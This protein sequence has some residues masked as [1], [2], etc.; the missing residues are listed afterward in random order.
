MSA[1]QRRTYVRA[2]RVGGWVAV[3]LIL[4]HWLTAGHDEITTPPPAP[5]PHSVTAALEQHRGECWH[6]GQ[7]ALAKVPGHVIWQYTDGTTVYSAS[8]VGPA[9]R[10][11]FD[12][13]HLP[14]RPIA[15]CL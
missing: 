1:H 9:L 15:F 7:P 11:I 10:T 4:T 5:A 14:G 13:G 8:L 3:A 2:L 6:D 12:G